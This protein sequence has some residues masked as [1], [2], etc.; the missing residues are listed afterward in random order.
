MKR[1]R[2]SLSMEC[3]IRIHEPNLIMPAC[4]KMEWKRGMTRILFFYVNSMAGLL[5]KSAVYFDYKQW[6][7]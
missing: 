2:H 3:G 5:L 1:N 6:F 7:L 4:L